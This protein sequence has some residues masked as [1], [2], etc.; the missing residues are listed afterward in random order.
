M[1][2]PQA[3]KSTS[4]HNICLFCAAPPQTCNLNIETSASIRG[5]VLEPPCPLDFCK[6]SGLTS[7]NG[8]LDLA[9]ALAVQVMNPDHPA[10]LAEFKAAVTKLAQRRAVDVEPRRRRYKWEAA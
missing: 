4:G 2:K 7:N 6:W 10:S 5:R 1:A 8:G 9:G 3:K